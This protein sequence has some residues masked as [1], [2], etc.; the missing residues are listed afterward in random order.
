MALSHR[1]KITEVPYVWEHPTRAGTRW[2]VFDVTRID[3]EA[4]VEHCTHTGVTI[5]T[6]VGF[7][8]A[9]SLN[10]ANGAKNTDEERVE[11]FCTFPAFNL[12]TAD[13]RTQ[14]LAGPDETN[15]KPS[16]F[17]RAS[18]QTQESTS[19]MVAGRRLSW[20]NEVTSA[21]QRPQG[22]LRTERREIQRNY[23]VLWQPLG[24]LQHS[25]RTIAGMANSVP[26]H[27]YFERELTTP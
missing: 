25:V 23:P 2:P 21:R 22:R 5:T 20:V 15:A 7:K 10:R 3:Q 19:D 1:H 13:T 17:E 11:P 6:V 12:L 9:E 18:G 24:P 8:K 27:S 16:R 4:P 14:R 26:R